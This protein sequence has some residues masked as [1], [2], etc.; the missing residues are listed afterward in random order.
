MFTVQGLP[1]GRDLAQGLAPAG[2]APF[3]GV[4]GE[5]SEQNSTPGLALAVGETPGLLAGQLGWKEAG[6]PAQALPARPAPPACERA[7]TLGGWPWR[8]KHLEGGERE[9]TGHPSAGRRGEPG[10]SGRLSEA[11]LAT[12]CQ[13]SVR[14]GARGGGEAEG[15]LQCSCS[16]GD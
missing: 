11:P 3:T 13:R 2:G 5:G 16:H 1:W 7:P 14:L 9:S 15:P 4:E 12:V 10:K 6:R 8:Q